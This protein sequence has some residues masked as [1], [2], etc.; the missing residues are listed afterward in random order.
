LKPRIRTAIVSTYCFIRSG[1]LDDTFRIARI[2]VNDDHELVQKAVGSWIREAGKQ[3][4]KRLLQFLDKHAT[5]M[6]RTILRYAV[7]KLPPAQRSS[8]SRAEPEP[9][10]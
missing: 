10:A 5:S 8:S 2:L 3:D 7:E 1:D 4:Q 9:G 6:P